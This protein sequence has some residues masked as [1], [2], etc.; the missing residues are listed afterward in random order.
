[1]FYKKG[2]PSAAERLISETGA[3]NLNR[4]YTA[5]VYRKLKHFK[6]GEIV[7]IT[8]LFAPSELAK[9]AAALEILIELGILKYS[10]EGMYTYRVVDNDSRTKK[11]L[12]SSLIYKILREKEE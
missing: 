4:D 10:P 12:E 8:G 11:Q 5:G 6:S 3:M 2:M 7:D 1:M 9:S